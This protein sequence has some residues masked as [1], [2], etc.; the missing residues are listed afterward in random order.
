MCVTDSGYLLNTAEPA[1]K[2]QTHSVTGNRTQRARFSQLHSLRVGVKLVFSVILIY[3]QTTLLAA[4]L[5][6]CFLTLV[7]SQH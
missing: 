6:K 4:F 2:R 5:L 3:D 1:R 7:L